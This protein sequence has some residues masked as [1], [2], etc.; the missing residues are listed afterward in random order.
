VGGLKEAE[1]IWVLAYEQPATIA[2]IRTTAPDDVVA[3]SYDT[4]YQAVRSLW[5]DGFLVRRKRDVSWGGTPYEY[6]LAE[7]YNRDDPDA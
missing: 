7:L 1:V 4:T 2:E 6:A 5:Q 3:S